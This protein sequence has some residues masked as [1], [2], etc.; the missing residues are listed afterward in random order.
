MVAK[1]RDDGDTDGATSKELTSSSDVKYADSEKKETGHLRKQIA[2]LSEMF[3]EEPSKIDKKR[4][5]QD[6]MQS[7][8]KRFMQSRAGDEDYNQWISSEGACQRTVKEDAKDIQAM[9]FAI[10]RG[11]STRAASVISYFLNQKSNKDIKHKV[12]ADI[13]NRRVYEQIVLGL[14]HSISH[15]TSSKGGTRSISAETFVK[16]VV[17]ASVFHMVA[18]GLEV[19][20]E[21]VI[22]HLGT[23]KRQINYA[24]DEIKSLMGADRPIKGLEKRMTRCDKV[25]DKLD[26]YVF[27]FLTNDEFTRVDTTKKQRAIVEPRSG[28]TCVVPIRTWKVLSRKKQFDAFKESA[29]YCEF[30]RS[31]DCATVGFT[32]FQNVLRKVGTFVTNPNDRESAGVRE[33]SGGQR[34]RM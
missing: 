28:N 5:R 22:K 12:L 8:A 20:V 27:D 2:S 29:H 4:K 18:E 31:H 14:K 16:N 11:D 34:V 10:S 30:Q 19:P 1:L 25:I 32:T 9:T 13:S 21:L 24:I 23:T 33:M 15:H 6:A 17:V 7:L 26:P 3:F